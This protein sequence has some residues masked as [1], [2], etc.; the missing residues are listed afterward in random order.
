MS[1]FEP[2]PNLKKSSIQ[3]DMIR[4]GETRQMIPASFRSTTSYKLT[5]SLASIKK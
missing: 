4:M 2:Q 5:V 3:D 1:G